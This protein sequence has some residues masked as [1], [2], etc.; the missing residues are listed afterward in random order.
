MPQKNVRLLN[1]TMDLI[2]M[3]PDKHNQGTWVSPCGSTMCYAGHAAVLDGAEF[4]HKRYDRD[5]DWHIDPETKKHVGYWDEDG[6]SVGAYAR[7]ALGLTW[8]ESDYLFDGDRTVEE[9][10]EAVRKLSAGYTISPWG[11]FIAPEDH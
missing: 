11:D 3:V 7:K 1:R 10:E 8:D 9:L 6:I 2:K 5:A 4:D